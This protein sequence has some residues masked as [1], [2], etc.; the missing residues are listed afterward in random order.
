MRPSVHHSMILALALGASAPPPAT[1][2][3]P[4]VNGT[5]DTSTSGWTNTSF[6]GAVG[7]PP[8]STNQSPDTPNSCVPGFSNCIAFSA[9]Q[10]CY[11][12]AQVF[13]ATGQPTDGE[14]ILRYGFYSDEAC[15]HVMSDSPDTIVPSSD[16]NHWVQMTAPPIV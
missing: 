5:F 14:A 7:N 11:L 1:A 4:I 8:G 9:G 6:E 10:T 2:S 13:F 15:A 12:T 16:Q 3:C